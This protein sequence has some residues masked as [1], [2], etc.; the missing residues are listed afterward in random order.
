MVAKLVKSIN[1]LWTS[2]IISWDLRG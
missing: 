1:M 2:R